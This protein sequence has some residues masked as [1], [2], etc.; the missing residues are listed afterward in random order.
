[1]IEKYKHLNGNEEVRGWFRNTVSNRMLRAWQE[2]N[3]L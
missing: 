1:M 2:Y 3:L